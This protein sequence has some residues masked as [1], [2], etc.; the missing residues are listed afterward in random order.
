MR[1]SERAIKAENQAAFD[2]QAALY[3][4]KGYGRF[5]LAMRERVLDAVKIPEGGLLLDVACG[6]GY[7]LMRA[8]KRKGAK[9]AGIDLS[10]GMVRLASERLPGN[11]NL[12]VGD[13]EHLPWP[14]GIFDVVTCT[15]SFHHFA[16]PQAALAE[17][18]RVLK[19]GGQ[20][21][22]ADAW[23]PTPFRQIT[24]AMFVP[25][26][27]E[28]DVRIYSLREVTAMLEAAQLKVV[29]WRRIGFRGYV[30]EARA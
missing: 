18:K 4:S 3:E 19:P 10:P 24:N 29:F 12:R 30:A 26:M 2:R 28:G 22:L 21:V 13:A 16:N 7:F 17:M 11:A 6:T 14:D 20:L 25:L 9:V 23:W 27:R 8:A 15:A 5:T 1:R